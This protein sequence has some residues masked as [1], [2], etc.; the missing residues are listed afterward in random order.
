MWAAGESDISSEE[1]EE[2]KTEEP[3]PSAPNKSAPSKRDYLSSLVS[4]AGDFIKQEL[5]TTINSKE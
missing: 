5:K 4:K 2:Q 3:A 1:I